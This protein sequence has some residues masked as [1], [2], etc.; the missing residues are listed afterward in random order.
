VSATAQVGVPAALLVARWWSRPTTEQRAQWAELWPEARRTAELLGL[1]RGLVA[2]L[3]HASERTD[4]EVLLEEYERLLVGPGRAPCAPY[5]SLWRGDL[6][7]EQRET[8]MGSAADE[9][10]RVYGAIGMQLR[11]DAHELPDHLLVE[12]E[13][14]ACA[15]DRGADEHAD[16]L[17]HDHLSIWVVPFC[18]AVAR[19]TKEAFYATL[20]E[21]TPAWTAAL[22]R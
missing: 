15:L 5:E 1:D 22:A 7:E 12:W 10:Q 2:Q 20:A 18:A 19:E 14:L 13:A 8:L 21:L 11:P 6:P 9:V 3:E 4:P 17:L 16:A